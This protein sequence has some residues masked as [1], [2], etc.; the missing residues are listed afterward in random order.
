MLKLT[1]DDAFGQNLIWLILI[2]TNELKVGKETTT[3]KRPIYRLD[4]YIGRPLPH[5]PVLMLWPTWTILPALMCVCISENSSLFSLSRFLIYCI[6][7]SS[8]SSVSVIRIPPLRPL[9]PVLLIF[10]FFCP[11]SLHF[12]STVA[13]FISLAHPLSISVSHTHTHDTH[14]N[15]HAPCA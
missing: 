6:S 9:L 13:S 5:S 4:R 14:K 8:W 2:W 15:H 11:L 7:P 12:C 10:L 1:R 3:K